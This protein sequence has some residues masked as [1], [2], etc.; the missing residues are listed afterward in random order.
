MALPQVGASCS[1]QGLPPLLLP[2][3]D[4]LVVAGEQNP[5][6][7]NTFP[8]VGLGVVRVLQ[9]PAFETLL[10]A[11]G[12]LSHDP[13]KQPDDGVEGFANAGACIVPGVPESCP[14]E[15]AAVPL[16]QPILDGVCVELVA[17]PD[18]FGNTR[19]AFEALNGVVF[20]DPQ[21]AG[22]P[23][24]KGTYHWDGA[25]GTF[26]WVD[27]ENDLLMVMM[28]QHLSYAAPPLQAQ[29]Q[30]LMSGAMLR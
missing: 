26:F 7:L 4:R 21:A 9:K 24:G 19:Y 30:A 8:E 1:C 29:S 11:R 2:P 23:V 28:T 16:L 13:G 10:L 6:N 5:R 3:G 18:S 20:T 15:K 27:P 22:V 12:L 17:E 25:A 14:P